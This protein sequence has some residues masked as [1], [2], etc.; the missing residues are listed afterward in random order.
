M[1]DPSFRK[2]LMGARTSDDIYAIFSEGDE[3]G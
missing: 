3:K 2:R 1:K